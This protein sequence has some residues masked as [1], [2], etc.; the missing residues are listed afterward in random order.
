[1]S[2]KSERKARRLRR[3][4][5]FLTVVCVLLAAMV[6]GLGS[7]A[8]GWYAK[9]D[10][11][12]RDARR[13]QAMYV[14]MPTAEPIVEPTAEPTG[15]PT[16]VPTVEPTAVPTVEPTAVPTVEPTAAPTV[17]P[18]GAPTAE[19]AATPTAA[20]TATPVP[21][22]EQ[23]PVAV[24]VPL[25]TANAD[26]LIL[27]LPTPPPVQASFNGLLAHNPDT[28][29]FL[30]IAGML[31]LPVVQREN[32]NDYYLN[33][34]FDGEQADEGALFLDGVNRLSPEDDCLIVYG[35]NMKN[36]TMF[37]MLNRYE[38]E[39]YVR[40]HPSLRFDTLYENREYVPFA[41][42]AASMDPSDG[43][44]FDVRNFLF[45]ETQYELFVL[46]LQARSVWRS[47]VDVRYG[48]RLLL[49]V[50]CDYTNRE[51]RFILALRQLRPGETA[52]AIS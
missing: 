49:L 15:T 5:R 18:T 37:G 44:Y 9:R 8:A 24:D 40:A 3:K 7:Y 42:F 48:D 6:L 32:D 45:D 23:E 13:Y 11:I 25:P 20:P 17:E 2:K 12:E 29:G 52:A 41:A 21:T 46:R 30:S 47:A 1:M 28:V 19:P 10:R 31:D 22:L 27:S 43:H 34:N 38:D 36:G 50:T 39:D 35:H 51:G 26:T 4:R 14:T 33:H 16:T